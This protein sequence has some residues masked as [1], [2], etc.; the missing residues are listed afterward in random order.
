MQSDGTYQ[1]WV[2]DVPV[3]GPTD[4]DIR[5]AGCW[6]KNNVLDKATDSAGRIV[7]QWTQNSLCIGNRMMSSGIGGV[8]EAV[9]RGGALGAAPAASPPPGIWSKLADAESNWISTTLIQLNALI[10]KSG[11]KPCAT[12]P[13]DP[14]KAMPAAVACFQG[15]YNANAGGSLPTDGTLDRATL[16]ALVAVTKEHA[17]DFPTP[18]PGIPPCLSALSMPMKIGIGVAAAL[19]VGGTVAAIASHDKKR[20]HN[21]LMREASPRPRSA[22][23]IVIDT[24]TGEILSDLFTRRAD[25][26]TVIDDLVHDHGASSSK[27]GFVEYRNGSWYRPLGVHQVMLYPGETYSPAT[28]RP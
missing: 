21:V 5:T 3:Q 15:W 25:A 12:W 11:N 18:Y 2:D 4:R 24:K 13:A 17:A 22:G 7:P 20:P 26:R 14:T 16:C 28:Y 8:G 19:V 9:R 1:D 6:W 27:P 10:L 23:F